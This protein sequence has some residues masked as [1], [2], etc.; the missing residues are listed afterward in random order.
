MNVQFL[1]TPFGNVSYRKDIKFCCESCS[2][3]V[4]E[5]FREFINQNCF[6][7]SGI[8]AVHREKLLRGASEV[9]WR[10]CRPAEWK[11]EAN[12]QKIMRKKL[13]SV[14][15]AHTRMERPREQNKIKS[16]LEVI[17][18]LMIFTSNFEWKGKNRSMTTADVYAAIFR[19]FFIRTIIN[20]S[21]AF[22]RQPTT[23]ELS[24][25]SSSLIYLLIAFKTTQKRFLFD[26]F[27]LVADDK[28]RQKRFSDYWSLGRWLGW[29]FD[30]S[31]TRQ[32]INL[33]V[34]Q[35]WQIKDFQREF[36]V[37][38]QVKLNNLLH[39]SMFQLI[40]TYLTSF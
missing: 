33:W 7:A 8:S 4:V 29:R 23:V 28:S 17:E 20:W 40:I 27:P 5:V 24:K 18:L 35:G 3:T 1:S 11:C 38:I 22:W 6:F 2:F 25:P 30:D 34:G 31:L 39:F 19:G 13:S 12:R 16:N 26:T 21:A 14:W 32:L 9:A 10:C 36:W 37:W 15:N